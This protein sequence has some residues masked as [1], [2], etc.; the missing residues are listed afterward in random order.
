[1]RRPWCLIRIIPTEGITNEDKD[2]RACFRL[3]PLDCLGLCCPSATFAKEENPRKYSTVNDPNSTSLIRQVAEAARMAA[4][5][6]L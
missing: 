2:N 4:D 6:I 3:P 5:L 1:M